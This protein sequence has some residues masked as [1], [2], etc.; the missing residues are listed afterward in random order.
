MLNNTEKAVLLINYCGFITLKKQHEIINNI[1]NLNNLITDLQSYKTEL[2]NIIN[3]QNYDKLEL[4][5]ESNSLQNFVANLE[6]TN[7]KVITILSDDYPELLKNTAD[8]PTVLY[9]RGNVKL[10]NSTCVAIVGTRRVSRYGHDVTKQF[11]EELSK[12]GLTIVSG[13]CDGVD[14]IAH[15]AC[16]NTKG[17][18]IAVIASGLNEIYPAT[19]TNLATNIVNGDG[20]II[21]EYKP[22]EKPKTFYFPNRNRII[23]GLSKAVLITEAPLKS[24]SL[25]TKNYALEYGREVFAVPGR[26]NDMYSAGC[27]KIIQNCQSAMALSPKTVLDFFGKNFVES[28]KDSVQLGL[29]D[30][31]ILSIIDVNEIHYEEILA[32]SQ[33]DSKTLNTCLM[34]LELKGIIKKLSGNFYSK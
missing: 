1:Q 19:N 7:I 25:Y 10:L 26:I 13:L 31:L 23:A 4:L 6:K 14:T 12:A 18:T 22:N 11:S 33:V 29:L 32:K 34:R 27:N 16:V 15:T 28:K 3:K 21:S 17:K 9:C 20:L 2:V 24:G 8:A 30:E 5:I